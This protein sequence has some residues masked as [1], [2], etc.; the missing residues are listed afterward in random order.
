M[1]TCH[2]PDDYPQ[3]GQLVG[4]LCAVLA[5]A[6]RPRPTDSPYRLEPEGW[7]LLHQLS[8]TLSRIRHFEHH[9]RKELTKSLTQAV[10]EYQASSPRPSAKPFAQGFLDGLSKSPHTAVVYLAV[11]YLKL[12]DGFQVA[13]V[14]FIDPDK[15]PEITSRMSTFGYERPELLCVVEATGGTRQHLSNRALNEAG[16]ALALIRQKALHGFGAKIYIPQVGF[17]L[18]GRYALEDVDGDLFVGGRW[19]IKFPELMDMT[20]PKLEEWCASLEEI[21]GRYAATAGEIRARCDTS[22]GWFDVATRSEDWRVVLPAIFTAIEALLVPGTQGLKAGL[23]TVRSVA[24]HAALDKPFFDPGEI[25]D[26]YTWRS[27]LIHGSP[28][29]ADDDPV[30]NEIA[31][32]R[33][34]WAFWVL[35]DFL[36]L[37]EVHGFTTAAEMVAFLES[38][39]TEAVCTWL[40][41][42][43][44]IDIVSEYRRALNLGG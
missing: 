39:K 12:P 29:P 15:M 5:V 2:V 3:R 1:Q 8:D 28:I 22:L 30:G 37:V 20:D 7:K 40:E 35:R 25:Q 44:L 6:R 36:E 27:K 38:E 4:N 26:G 23:V 16:H 42:H 33:R 17:Y 43:G 41:D 11:R 9:T 34:L 31:N 18:D 21:S 10:S 24:V 32:D 13:G 19:S 14:R